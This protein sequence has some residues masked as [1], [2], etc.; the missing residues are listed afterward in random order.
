MLFGEP[1][2]EAFLARL[3]AGGGALISPVNHWEVLI[4]ANA[5]RGRQGVAEAETL[6]SDLR[7]SPARVD[8]EQA[9][10]AADAAFRFG[11]GTPAKLNLGDCFAYALALHEG[12]GLLYK[13]DDFPLTDIPSAL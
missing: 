3:G 5:A 12:E 7:I 9:R 1:E 2:A 10:V 6:M 8:G 11:R 13:G 4:R